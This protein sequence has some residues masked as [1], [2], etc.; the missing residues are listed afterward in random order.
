MD[1][2]AIGLLMYYMLFAKL[3]FLGKTRE[4][5]AKN[6]IESPVLFSNSPLKKLKKSESLSDVMDLS[7]TTP[8]L[9]ESSIEKSMQII[10][11]EAKDLMN[12][13]LQKAPEKRISMADIQSH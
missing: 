8:Q 6:V 10:T 7:R 5:L 11:D 3:P 13:M 9:N 12:K 4:E 1:V 2:W